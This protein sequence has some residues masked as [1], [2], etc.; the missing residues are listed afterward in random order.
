MPKKLPEI[1]ADQPDLVNTCWNKTSFR[2]NVLYIYYA[3]RWNVFTWR[4]KEA[5]LFFESVNDKKEWEKLLN[6]ARNGFSFY[7]LEFFKNY[8][9]SLI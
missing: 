3:F 2:H 1:G 5:A 9:L 6:D 8:F 4:L 7:S